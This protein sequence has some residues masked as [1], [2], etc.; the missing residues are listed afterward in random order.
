M[1][2]NTLPGVAKRILLNCK[3]CESERFHIVLAHTGPES[4]K[5]EC[6]VCHSKK[7]YKTPKA[8]ARKSAGLAK[9][10]EDRILGAHTKQYMDLKERLAQNP[11]AAYT[12]KLSYKVDHVIEHPKFGTGFVVE[13]LP[14]KIHVAFQDEVKTLVHNRS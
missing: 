14:D 5:V 4:A 13:V 6:E 1:S 12:M 8:Q 9:K 11:P 10:R 3:K 7:T 2:E